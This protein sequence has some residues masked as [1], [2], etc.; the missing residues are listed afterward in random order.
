MSQKESET[1]H[2]YTASGLS[3]V[4]DAMSKRMCAIFCLPRYIYHVNK[5]GK[6]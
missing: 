1:H 3:G 6:Y 2:W 4:K 5:I